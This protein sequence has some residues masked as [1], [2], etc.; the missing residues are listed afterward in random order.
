MADECH[1]CL[2]GLIFLSSLLTGIS[3]VN[4][5]HVFISSEKELIIKEGL[6]NRWSKMKI[7][8]KACMKQST[9]PFL[10]LQETMSR[11]MM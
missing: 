6:M 9:C 5:T 11:Q 7:M 10:L 2:L 3:G 4:K 8:I 1:L